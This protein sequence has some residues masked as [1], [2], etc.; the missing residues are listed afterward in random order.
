MKLVDTSSWIEYLREAKSDASDRVE[1][2]VLA[3]EA[4]WCDMTAVE[5]WHG[6]RGTREK[7]ELAALEREIELI[8][9][10]ARAWSTARQLARRCREAGV[11]V[12]AADLIIA[13]CAV[14]HKIEF[15][16]CDAHFEKILPIAARL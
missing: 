8:P 4:G 3:G 5:L 6:A 11:T 7:R 2:L 1:E 9:V 12:P 13:A 16:H 15:E 14:A 10:D